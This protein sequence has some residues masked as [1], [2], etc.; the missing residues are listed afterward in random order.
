MFSDYI[1]RT[2]FWIYDKIRYN[3]EVKKN[4]IEIKDLLENKK[5]NKQQLDRLLN[6][7]VKTSE[8]YKECNPKDITSFPI[9]DKNIIKSKWNELYSSEYKGKPVHKMSTSGSTGTPFVMDWD[10]GK[11]KRQLAELIY[12]NEI[13]GQKLGQKYIYFRVWTARNKKS[14]MELWMQN[15][16]PINILQLN[17]DNLE[18]IRKRLK[19]KPHINSC[20]AYASTYEQLVNYISSKGDT[21]KDFHTKVLVSGSEVLSME[22]KE[23]IKDTMGCAVVDRYSNEENGFLAQT[24]D[25]SDE[26]LVNTSG[27]FIEIL[28]QDSDEPVEI[29]ELGRIVVTDL[30]SFAVPLIRY[31]TGDLAILGEKKDTWTTML[32]T[33]QGRKVDLIYDTHGN[34]MTSHTW[35][36]YMWK[37]DKIKQYQF[38]QK[39]PKEYTLK[40]NGAK[41]FYTDE[42]FV[43]L[44]KQILGEEAQVTIEHVDGIP[45]L[46][47][48]KFK[49]TICEYQYNPQ[50]YENN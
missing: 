32:K 8:F 29:G 13:I 10:I 4:Y 12:L 36:V 46:K 35:G 33:I 2:G 20:L 48:G 49:K 11:R 41:E 26:F 47:S 18:K 50:D 16:V 21:P 6:H 42:E 25:M 39:G 45:S 28:K 9:I 15:L 30:Y 43:E 7:A 38:I 1:R 44:I 34:K 27:F 19:K 3:G 40:V 37:F 17:D 14:K 5:L 22:M 23:K 24:R 31:D